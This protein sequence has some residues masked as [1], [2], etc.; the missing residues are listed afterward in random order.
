MPVSTSSKIRVSTV[1]VEASTVFM[2]S[3]IR[4][5]SPPEAIFATG[6]GFSPGLAEIKSSILS[7]PLGESSNVSNIGTSSTLGILR[8]C[9]SS[10]T[11][12]AKSSAA[13]LR[14]SLSFSAAD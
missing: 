2:A 5:S 3:I 7:T 11:F 6:L 8:N 13:V 10:L 4:E 9:I 12:L 1:S 14:F